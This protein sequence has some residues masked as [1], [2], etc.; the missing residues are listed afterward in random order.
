MKRLIFKDTQ[1][2]I[3]KQ[4]LFLRMRGVLNERFGAN[5]KTDS[6]GWGGGGM[7]KGG[8]FAAKSRLAAAFL[9]KRKR[10]FCSVA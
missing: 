8:S 9:E 3:A 5:V 7:G 10:L 1:Y 2:N 4:W 6:V